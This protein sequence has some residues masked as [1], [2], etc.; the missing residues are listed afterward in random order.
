M[1]N[2]P[3]RKRSLPGRPEGRKTRRAAAQFSLACLIFLV[4]AFAQNHANVTVDLGQKVNVLT[5]SSLGLPTS[6]SNAD[7]FSGAAIPW[8]RAAGISSLRFP[9]DRDLADLY[10]WST[11][12]TV[13]Y[14]GGDLGFIAPACNFARFALSAEQLGQGVIVVNYGSNPN[15]TGGGEPE[16]A[17][18]WVA[19]ANGIPSDIH[20]LGKDSTGRD[21]QTVGYWAAL[22]S[23]APLPKDDGLNF[24]RIR[25]PRPFGFHLW[26]VG[27]EVYN[28][29]Y[30]GD[31]H[32]GDPDLHAPAP[33]SPK[34][35][36]KLKGNPNLSP[37]AYAA[38]F[39]RFAKAMKAVDPSIEV[40]AAFT[41]PPSPDPNSHDW[42]PDWDKEV[43]KRACA[44]I[45]FVIFDWTLQPLLPPDWKTLDEASL[46]QN[47]GYNQTNMIDL[48]LEPMLQDYKRYCP[49]GHL[50]RLAFDPVAI[51]TWVQVQH[52][53]VEALWAA[54]F[55]G[56][57]IESGSANIDWNEM[58][59]DSML[60]TNGG[61]PGPVFYGLQMLHIVAYRPG[62]ML[63]DA[64]SN[65]PVLA[66]HA[67]RRRD[68]IVGLMLINKDPHSATEVK[69]TFRNGSV[70]TTG[71]RI[72]YG[73]AQFAA[74]S[75]PTV[76]AFSAPGDEFTVTVPA[77][78]ITDILLPGRK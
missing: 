7:C 45:D 63:V 67:T 16:E 13:P 29:G 69:V 70:G 44:D 54:D 2:S 48:L 1:R 14:K 30:Y 25:H 78:T 75:G 17:A 53:V 6:M 40:G 38:N 76:S 19:Y 77:Y 35:P 74:K 3:I 64:R 60:S 11:G 23:E 49:A 27:D 59:G 52:P 34:D 9:G 12:A 51:A 36:G 47:Q 42:A 5:D 73:E 18:A 55:Y 21:W 24:L 72:E 10:H 65:S 58:Y 15:G 68:G 71:R 61:K 66:V 56:L 4:P 62:D 37:A 41:V 39:Q 26:Q 8:L 31:Q 32:T 33:A 46:L 22:R 50:P 20:P 57:L 28:N 43:L